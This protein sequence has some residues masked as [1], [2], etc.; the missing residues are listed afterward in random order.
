MSG[1]KRLEEVKSLVSA[2]PD[3]PKK[4][5]LFRNIFPVLRDV[6][7]FKT[8]CD[9]IVEHIKSTSPDVELI[10]GLDSRG[11]LFGPIIA[12]LLGIGFAPVR[13]S[14]KLPG[15]TYKVSYK[16]EYG[17]DSFEIEKSS[18]KQDQ[19]I[20]IIDDLIATGGSMKAACELVEK[21]GGNILQCFVVIELN[22]LNGRDKVNKPVH[23][24]LTY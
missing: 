23:S 10:V 18:I 9:L 2:H 15:E 6:H 14:G 21:A 24:L 19:K 12:Q 11:F 1:N 4:G 16:L 20:L 3:F 17:E 22:C 13:K 8:L 5:V 7:G